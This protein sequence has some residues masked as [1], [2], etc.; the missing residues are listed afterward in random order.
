MVVCSNTSL[1]H[2]LT[3]L[4][5][6]LNPQ[7]STVYVLLRSQAW[8]KD[9]LVERYSEDPS[10]V[11]KAAGVTEL[12]TP[13]SSQVLSPPSSQSGASRKSSRKGPTATSPEEPF[14]CPICCDDDATIRTLALG[15]GHA[16]CSNCWQVYLHTKIHDEGEVA[17]RCMDEACSIQADDSFIRRAATSSDSA[18]YTD[19]LVRDFVANTPQ[20]KFCPHP[21]CSNALK[22][23]AAARKGA[24]NV[25]V[26]TVHCAENH[27]FCF[28][29]SA[30]GGHKPV[31]C[32]VA[33]MWLKKCA[34]DSETANWIKSNTKECP[35]CQ[36]TIEKNGGCK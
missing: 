24:L 20:I 29:C 5:D 3:R 19:L 32:S 33:K 12:P 10:E 16:Y 11:M 8:K 15:C 27:E 13:S 6:F 35:K 31:I 36:S 22:C 34:D 17:V 7:I 14:M 4:P 23:A 1:I 2:I 21:G 30:A 18:R 25:I 9:R 26:P 28:G